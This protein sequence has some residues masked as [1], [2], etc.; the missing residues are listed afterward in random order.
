MLFVSLGNDPIMKKFI[1]ILGLLICMLGATAQSTFKYRHILITNDDGIGDAD[2]LLALARSVKKVAHRV[3]IVVSTFDRSGTSNQLTFGKHTS[4]IEV[5]CKYQDPENNISA[6]VTP[7]NPADCV[8]IGLSGLFGD[9][10]PDL[11]LSGINGGANIGLGWF[12]SGTI[13]AVRTSAFL[14]VPGVALS[15]F[16]DDD[17]RSFEVI[18]NWITELISTGLIDLLGKNSYLT[19]GFPDNSLEEIKGIKVASRKISFDQP[20][21]IVFKKIYGEEIDKPE[22]TTV[23]T[24]E[25]WGITPS[26]NEENDASYLQEGYIVLTPMSIDENHEQLLKTFETQTNLIPEF[27]MK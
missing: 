25:D 7:G 6:Y 17:P 8:L 24:L 12:S 26:P 5:T 3:T 11:V 10:R 16:D 27:S 9:D 13:G 4:T 15:G 19:V 20:E 2:R 21:S 22:N 1:P 14:G 18:P 23:W